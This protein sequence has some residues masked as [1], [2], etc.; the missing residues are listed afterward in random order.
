[1]SELWKVAAE[2]SDRFAADALRYDRF[3]PRYP[4]AVFDDIVESGRLRPGDRAIEVGAGTGIAT[5]PLVERGL[6]VTAVEPAGAMAA[7]AAAR[8]ADRAAFVVG[9]F[10]D[11]APD[12]AS[13]RLVADFNAWHW[14]DPVTALDLTAGVLEPGGSL[15]LVWTE[16]VS[17]GG[18]PFED[19][20]AET[21]G[22][23]W[24]KRIDE[25]GP[26]D[27]TGPRRCPVR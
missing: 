19:R 17:W 26:V 10:E 13:V 27:A 24:E 4:A 20:L 6:A 8:L 1:M 12:P 22:A 5:G 3:R 23:R 11:L 2:A 16:V 14:V 18:V 9:R 21:F 25:V 7:V 15:A